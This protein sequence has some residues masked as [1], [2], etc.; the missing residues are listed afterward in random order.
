MKGRVACED[1]YD[2]DNKRI[3]RSTLAVCVSVTT[4][5]LT[6]SISRCDVSTYLPCK[7]IVNKGHLIDFSGYIST[8]GRFLDGEKAIQGPIHSIAAPLYCIMHFSYHNRQMPQAY[9]RIDD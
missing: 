1:H 6:T 7:G 3:S 5:H 9:P 4:A 2:D 8:Q